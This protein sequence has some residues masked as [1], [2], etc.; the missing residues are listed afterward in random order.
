MSN[1]T[2]MTFKCVEFRVEDGQA[3]FVVPSPLHRRYPDVS[4]II[5]GTIQ[6]GNALNVGF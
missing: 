1:V 3:K 2:G 4:D 5:L 6:Y